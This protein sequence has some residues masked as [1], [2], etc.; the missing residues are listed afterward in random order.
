MHPVFDT[1]RLQ[2]LIGKQK[3]KSGGPIRSFRNTECL[4]K[5]LPG[6]KMFGGENNGIWDIE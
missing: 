2:T 3:V 1:E 6:Y 5:K 4:S